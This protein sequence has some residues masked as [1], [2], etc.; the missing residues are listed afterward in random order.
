MGHNV[1]TTL[2]RGGFV[3]NGSLVVEPHAIMASLNCLRHRAINVL[4]WA[5]GKGKEVF[6]NL[7][8]FLH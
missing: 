3:P 7:S 2:I 6:V 5:V 4:L 8:F 1:V